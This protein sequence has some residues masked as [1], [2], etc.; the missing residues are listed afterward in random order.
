MAGGIGDFLG[1][2]GSLF[3]GMA[4]A[5]DGVHVRIWHELKPWLGNLLPAATRKWLPYITAGASCEVPVM[6]RGQMVG[7]CQH[8]AVAACDVCH[9]P[10]CLHHGRIDQFGDAI[11]YICV[12]DA[13]QVVPQLQR[14]RARAAGTARPQ[15]P[16]RG[17]P[18]P[19]QKPGPSPLEVVEAL[20]VLGLKP[21]AKWPAVA[22]AHRKLS[23]QL[24]PDRH[25]SQ[26]KK[27]AANTTY[28]V[29]QG[30]FNLLRPL[31]DAQAV[32]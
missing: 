10:V 23:A 27:D 15:P 31:Y 24:H 7:D 12:S 18:P 26:R 20:S 1:S 6:Q 16:P 25:Q 22:A 8:F 9:R 28:V 2:L 19:A 14:E 29:V 21:G 11:C 4:G 17:A 5:Q 32:S 13:L 3:G 30:A